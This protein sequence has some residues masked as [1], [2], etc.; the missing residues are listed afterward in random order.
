MTDELNAPL[1]RRRKSVDSVGPRFSVRTLPLAS[2]GF[3]IVA[4]ALLAAGLRITLVDDP[5]GGHPSATVEVGA[6]SNTNSV[7]TEVASN[8]VIA[9][10][11]AVADGPGTVKITD[12]DTALADD[13]GDGAPEPLAAAKLNELGINPELVEKTQNGPIPRIGR[14]GTTPFAA[15]SRASVSPGA[16][17][18]KPLIAIVVTGMGLSESGTIEAA[19]KLPGA[20]TLAFAPYGRSL[21]RTTA[22]AR[23]DGHEMLLQIPLEPFDYPQNDPGPQTLLTGQPPRANL[24]RLFWLMARFGGY[25]GLMNH[26]GARF[27]ASAG[28]FEPIMEEFGVRGLGYFDDGA[29]NRSL[30]PQL[31]TKNRVPFAHADLTLDD[32]PTRPAILEALDTL[33]AR[34][35]D[36]GS[37]IGVISA[38]P[39]SIQTV[40]EWAQKLE[41]RGI[42]LVPISALMNQ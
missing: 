42:I 22:A 28:D 8:P 38:L 10:E 18:G 12:V 4:I 24:D 17:N 16:A 30:A 11:P 31:A 21:Q 6:I 34:A 29:S 20:I 40:A 5:Q 13:T 37:A 23:A 15:Y 14:D 3:A 7:A 35:R 2:V 9:E 36:T 26:M 32:T 41:G 33:E 19:S 39:V 27:T 25:V 1:G